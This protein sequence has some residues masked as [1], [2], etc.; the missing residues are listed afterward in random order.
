MNFPPLHLMFIKHPTFTHT[1]M[2]ASGQFKCQ[3]MAQGYINMDQS[4]DL[5]V[6]LKP[7]LEGVQLWALT[8]GKKQ[9]HLTKEFLYIR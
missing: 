1:L 5:A 4:T 3:H 9:K 6:H 8:L 2:D 7:Q